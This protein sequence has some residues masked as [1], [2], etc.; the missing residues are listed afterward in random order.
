MDGY[1]RLGI[2]ADKSEKTPA[3]E[4]GQKYRVEFIISNFSA[5]V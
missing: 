4:L 3:A 5:E 1:R 2:V